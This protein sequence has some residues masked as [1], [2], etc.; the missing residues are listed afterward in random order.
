MGHLR[1]ADAAKNVV[2]YGRSNHRNLYQVALGGF[3]AFADRIWNCSRFPETG[4]DMAF[5][6]TDYH[7]DVP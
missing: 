7:Q 2:R 3:N 5:A 6:I 1:G 4:A